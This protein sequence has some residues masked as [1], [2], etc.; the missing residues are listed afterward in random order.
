V[1][2]ASW[3]GA[4][5]VG[6]EREDD[7]GAIEA[8][9][10]VDVVAEGELRARASVVAARGI[11]LMPIRRR[12][13]AEEIGNLIGER[14]RADRLGEEAK[15]SPLER[16]LCVQ[17]RANR[18]EESRPRPNLAERHERLRSIGIVQAEDGRLR[19]DVGRAQ[20]ARVPWVAFHLGRPSLVAFDQQ[21]GRDAAE[22]HRRRKEQRP[23]RNHL[24]GLTDEGDD[25]FGR[26]P[27]AGGHT[28]EC[29]RCTHQF[30]KGAALHGIGNR[31]G[32]RQQ[33]G[34]FVVEILAKG[35]TS[36]PLLERAPPVTPAGFGTWGLG[37]VFRIPR[38]PDSESQI[39]SRMVAHRWHV[40]QLVSF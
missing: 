7:V 13:A 5:E 20:A 39:P 36:R 10:A 34:K 30:Q 40:E 9:L 21:A 29:Q 17:H 19:E 25:R 6:V 1:T 26:L 23:A 33:R 8:V 11:P 31:F 24:L 3:T 37:F 14:W 27:R 22:R 12:V 15:A 32:L 18:A 28:G 35:R 16:L 2:E 38:I 4:Q